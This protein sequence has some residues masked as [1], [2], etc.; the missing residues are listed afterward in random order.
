M[1]FLHTHLYEELSNDFFM[2]HSKSKTETT[3][4]V[5]SGDIDP[6]MFKEVQALVAWAHEEGLK[7]KSL[8]K[9]K[10]CGDDSTIQSV[11]ITSEVYNNVL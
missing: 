2:E 10:V 7:G 11:S 5:V 8:G 1:A 3:Q 4:P 6:E 9:V